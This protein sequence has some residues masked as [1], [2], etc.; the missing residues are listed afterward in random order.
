MY[1]VMAIDVE[2]KRTVR[3]QVE[4]RAASGLCLH[5]DREAERLGLCGTHYHQYRMSLLQ[6]P[7]SEREVWK[8]RQIRDGKVLKT[9]QGQRLYPNPFASD[10]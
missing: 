9:R 3:K 1:M 8:A 4:E 7:A 6:K 2:P 5:C 10:E